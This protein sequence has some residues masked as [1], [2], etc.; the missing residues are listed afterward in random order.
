MRRYNWNEATL[1]KTAL[2]LVIDENAL[3][4]TTKLAKTKEIET[5][6]NCRD[7]RFTVN[8]EPITDKEDFQR[9]IMSS[10]NYS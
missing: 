6:F 10:Y 3:Q 4:D 1:T 5:Y 8:G 2:S 9:F 7:F